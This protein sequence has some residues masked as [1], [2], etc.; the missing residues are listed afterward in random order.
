[1]KSPKI[2]GGFTHGRSINESVLNKWAYGLL[3]RFKNVVK[4][5][6]ILEKIT[7]MQVSLIKIDNVDVQKLLQWLDCH[8]P[9]VLIKKIMYIPSGATGVEKINFHDDIGFVLLLCKKKMR[10][11]IFELKSSTFTFKREQ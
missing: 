8:Y 9:F 1:M 4:F 5:L 3:N 2:K 11:N 7:W 10:Y 6:L